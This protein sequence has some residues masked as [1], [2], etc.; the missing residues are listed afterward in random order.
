MLGSD[1]LKM[2]WNGNLFHFHVWALSLSNYQGNRLENKALQ[3]E[4]SLLYSSNHKY[5]L[6]S[7]LQLLVS[8]C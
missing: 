5:K 4:G 6:L 7:A 8:R 1:G 3:G 2:A